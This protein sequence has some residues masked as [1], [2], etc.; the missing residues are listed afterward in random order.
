MIEL[1]PS[2][3]RNEVG[4]TQKPR[5]CQQPKLMT[6]IGIESES[7]WLMQDEHGWQPVAWQL[8]KN[9]AAHSLASAADDFV[10]SLR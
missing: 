7:E 4:Q 9:D 5:Q 2:D 3:G 6:M 8:A 10:S 1:R